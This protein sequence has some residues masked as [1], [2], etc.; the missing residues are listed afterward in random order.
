MQL[1]R[2]AKMAYCYI[3]V[4]VGQQVLAVLRTW[5]LCSMLKRSEAEHYW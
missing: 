5:H 3:R 4:R 1:Q 2:L